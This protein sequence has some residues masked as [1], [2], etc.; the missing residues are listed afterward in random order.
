MRS[1]ASSGTSDVQLFNLSDA[2]YEE[3]NL[4]DDSAYDSIQS[5]MLSVLRTYERGSMD[6]ITSV[7]YSETGTGQCNPGLNGNVWTYFL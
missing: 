2:P 5:D 7:D 1:T 3:D 6:P 4:A